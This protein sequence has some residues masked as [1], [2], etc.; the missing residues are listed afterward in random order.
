V[1]PS[2]SPA[3]AQGGTSARSSG[4]ALSFVSCI[5][6]FDGSC[7]LAQ[8]VGYAGTAAREKTGMAFVGTS[9]GTKSRAG[10]R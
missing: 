9:I 7:A 5:R 8:A 6:L 4:A 3:G 10:K 2:V 1:P